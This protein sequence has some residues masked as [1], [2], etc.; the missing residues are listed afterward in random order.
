[1]KHFIFFVLILAAP[2]PLFA[3]DKAPSVY[4]P[5]NESADNKE[6]SQ[7]SRI[8]SGSV[9]GL[10]SGSD[11]DNP[12]AGDYPP[13]DKDFEKACKDA[14]GTMS[15]TQGWGGKTCFKSL[16]D[17]YCKGATRSSQFLRAK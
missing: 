16:E 12:V 4:P 2:L 14:G 10:R 17:D 15:D 8:M 3:Q 11:N 5:K 9:S 6:T 13:C 7:P 1:M